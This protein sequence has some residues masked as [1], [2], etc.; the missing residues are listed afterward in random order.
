MI[1]RLII[2]LLIV[3]CDL[4]FPPEDEGDQHDSRLIA[5]WYLDEVKDCDDG[6][7]CD[8]SNNFTTTNFKDTILIYDDFTYEYLWDGDGIDSDEIGTWK[9]QSFSNKMDSIFFYHAYCDSSLDNVCQ[10]TTQA[11]RTDVKGYTLQENTS[12]NYKEDYKLTFYWQDGC[13]E[14]I[15]YTIIP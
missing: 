15:F 13:W 14:D 5:S 6:T 2:L 8:C 11:Y 3:G 1:R 4:I 10:D 7:G 12:T 9:T